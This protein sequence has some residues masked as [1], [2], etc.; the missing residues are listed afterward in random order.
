MDTVSFLVRT[1]SH[2]RRDKISDSSEQTVALER[3]IMIL[4][5][6][7]YDSVCFR[8]RST[9]GTAVSRWLCVLVHQS[10]LQTWKYLLG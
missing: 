4:K 3:S 5:V 7:E 8:V 10:Q 6:L 2:L 1:G 9:E